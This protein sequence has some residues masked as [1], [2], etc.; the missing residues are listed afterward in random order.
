MDVDD[1]FVTDPG[2]VPDRI[3]DLA[4][5]ERE[6]GLGGEYVQDVELG[7]GERDRDASDPDLAS[8]GVD[9]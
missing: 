4:T 6:A 9:A 1:V 3:D 8:G 7:A 5:A 2:G